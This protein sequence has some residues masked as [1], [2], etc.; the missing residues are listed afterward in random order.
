[1]KIIEI[2]PK[3]PYVE[4]IYDFIDKWFYYGYEYLPFIFLETLIFEGQELQLPRWIS[5][6]HF[7]SIDVGTQQFMLDLNDG[8]I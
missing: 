3:N 4:Y 5:K 2:D 8:N 1:M 6:Q 7:D